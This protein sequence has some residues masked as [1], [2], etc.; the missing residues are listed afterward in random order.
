MCG[1]PEK[2]RNDNIKSESSFFH[3]V[4]L[5]GSSK[6][7]FFIKQESHKDNTDSNVAFLIAYLIVVTYC[8][9]FA[10]E[11]LSFLLMFEAQA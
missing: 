8:I 11:L 4:V 1:G 2:E 3:S 9:K 7:G 10:F 5:V 6:K